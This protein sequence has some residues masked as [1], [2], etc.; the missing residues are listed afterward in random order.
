MRLGTRELSDLKALAT[1]CHAVPGRVFTL[2]AKSAAKARAIFAAT[3]PHL[4]QFGATPNAGRL[5][6]E[7]DNGST[8]RVRVEVDG[9]PS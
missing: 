9:G 5:Q 1:A 2:P 4:E 3:A 6:A 7:F 8:I